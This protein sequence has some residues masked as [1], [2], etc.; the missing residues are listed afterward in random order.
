MEVFI[1]NYLEHNDA[2]SLQF[3]NVGGT[4]GGNQ[5]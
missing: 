1:A 4:G 3:Y 5:N 2:A